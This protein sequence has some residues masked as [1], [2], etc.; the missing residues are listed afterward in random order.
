[1][2]KIKQ[3]T[4]ELLNSVLR[5]LDNDE[6]GVESV[7]NII[8]R[9]KFALNDK[10][11]Q[12]IL[13]KLAKDGYAESGFAHYIDGKPTTLKTFHITFHGRLFLS[14]GGYISESRTRTANTA[15]T[16]LKTI[17]AAANAAAIVIIAFWTLSETQ[18]SRE[19][20]DKNKQEI[21]TISKRLD[22]LIFKK[23][24]VFIVDKAT[25]P[26]TANSGLP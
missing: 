21:K 20:D 3:T 19:Q 4:E 25:L 26:H 5:Y 16:I 6:Q 14:R 24:T 11:A 17:A 18:K 1:M 22:S 2:G 8:K 7:D 13:D 9:G 15:W 23:D 12:L 10:D